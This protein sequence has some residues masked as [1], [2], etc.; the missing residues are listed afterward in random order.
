MANY[1]LDVYLNGSEGED[2]VSK[3]TRASIEGAKMSSFHH[4]NVKSINFHVLTTQE[5]KRA[6][7]LYLGSGLLLPLFL[8]R[9]AEGNELRRISG[10]DGLKQLYTWL[11]AAMSELVPAL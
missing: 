2:C 8:L 3:R 6:A 9:D 1:T 4:R 11:D 5:D 7:L 10:F